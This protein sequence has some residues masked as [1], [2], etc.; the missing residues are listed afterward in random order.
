LR[1]P[2][3]RSARGVEAYRA[4][5]ASIAERALAASFETVRQ[6]V[7]G[8]AFA[9]LA[10]GFWL[11][12]PPLRGDLAEWGDAFPSWLGQHDAMR[13]LPYL[14]DCARLD[15]AVHD[16]ER[17]ADAAFDAASLSVLAS[18][19]PSTLRLRLMPGTVLLRSSWPIASL[20][21]AHRL[22]TDGA[23]IA[24]AEVRAAIAARQGQD[25]MVVRRGWRAALHCVDGPTAN[26]VQSLL[27][28]ESLGQALERA[29]PDFDF[30]VWLALAVRESWL[31]G[32]FVERDNDVSG[33]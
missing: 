4:N 33:V 15:R 25:V 20:H 9:A 19:E 14:E 5:A 30:S 10:C 27:R 22:G 18:A 21:A 24:F 12:H 8:E 2:G 28:H 6:L 17:A 29:G 1:E 3:D 26:W 32:A 31:Q 7:G 13:S 23:D 16:N 11:A